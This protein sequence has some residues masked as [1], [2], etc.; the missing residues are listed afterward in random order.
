MAQTDRSLGYLMRVVG[1]LFSQESA[2]VCI[3]AVNNIEEGT[4]CAGCEA[5]IEEDEGI[6]CYCAAEDFGRAHE[7]YRWCTQDCFNRTH[8]EYHPDPYD[9]NDY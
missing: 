4:A 9:P 2:G 8:D 7:Q 5:P 1:D 6:E 3:E